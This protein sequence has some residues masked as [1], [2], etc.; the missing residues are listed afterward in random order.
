MGRSYG[1]YRG[2]HPG[3]A[4]RS[5][6]HPS[7][8][9]PSSLQV[10]KERCQN[11]LE[12][13]GSTRGP[14]PITPLNYPSLLTPGSCFF[15]VSLSSAARRLKPLSW[16]ALYSARKPSSS[17][18]LTKQSGWYQRS[19]MPSW[20]FSGSSIFLDRRIWPCR[21]NHMWYQEKKSDGDIRDLGTQRLAGSPAK[22]PQVR[23][24]GTRRVGGSL[25]LLSAAKDCVPAKASVP[26]F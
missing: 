4:E 17:L 9:T 22:G 3:M 14:T 6:N 26:P 21:K 8:C 18:F 11:S 19:I 24:K 7:L 12:S 1:S 2:M 23:T 5:H 13:A 25:G 15:R 10:S 16:L 20:G